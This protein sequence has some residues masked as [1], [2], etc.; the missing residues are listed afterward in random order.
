M[1]RIAFA[2][3]AG[4]RKPP[5]PWMPRPARFPPASAAFKAKASMDATDLRV[6]LF[7][8]NYNMVRDGANKSL[9]RLVGHMLDRGAAMRVYSP[10]VDEPAFDPVGDLVSVPSFALPMRGEYRVAY[11]MGS[12]VKGDLDAF[13]PNIVHIA[14][15]DFVPHQAVRWARARGLPVV[16]SVHTRFETYFQYYNMGFME[17]V[18]VAGL[19]KL[20]NRCDALVVPSESTEEVL[21]EQGV[22]SPITIWARGVEQDIFD[23][24][25]RDCAWR[26]EHGIAD[27]EVAIVF[28]GR[29][30]MEKGLDVFAD[31][32]AELRRRNL[33]PRVLVIGDG[34][35][36]AWFEKQLPE[37]RFVGFQSGEDLGR[38]LASGDLFFNP[39]I[40]ETFGNVTLEAM[41]CG[42]PVIASAATGSRSLVVDGE[43]G[44]LVDPPKAAGFADAIAPYLTDAALRQ[45]HGAAGQK[46]SR[47]FTWEAVND[48][49]AGVYL[50]QL[51]SKCVPAFPLSG[52][53]PA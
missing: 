26:R 1:V 30:V 52:A 25:R 24:R 11:R 3:A 14:A 23:A 10:T 38:A 29:L 34:P 31:T 51:E 15:P 19:R 27:D 4:G 44:A 22:T 49:V 41:A 7:T 8:G 2:N 42:L 39:S 18:I 46:R 50:E 32:I 45:A 12:A 6:A 47:L 37:G 28:L 16:A 21:R 9:N 43:T 48:A 20:Y 13:R 17:P 35:H 40:T 33:N 53:R 36:R 5:H